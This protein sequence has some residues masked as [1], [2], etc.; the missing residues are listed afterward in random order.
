M[1][2]EDLDLDPCPKGMQEKKGGC[3]E[4]RSLSSEAKRSENRPYMNV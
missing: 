3:L 4:E 2:I 1:D